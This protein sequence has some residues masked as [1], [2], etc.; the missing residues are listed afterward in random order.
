[1]RVFPEINKFQEEKQLLQNGHHLKHRCLEYSYRLQLKVNKKETEMQSREKI[2][3][4]GEDLQ[5]SVRASLIL[6][7]STI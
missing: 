4:N 1:M 7:L 2:I 5:P 3:D 6:L